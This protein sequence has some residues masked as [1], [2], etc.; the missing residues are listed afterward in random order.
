[1]FQQSAWK[2]IGRVLVGSKQSRQKILTAPAL[3]DEATESCE[4]A[5]DG[6]LLAPVPLDRLALRALLDAAP[7][8][9]VR[10]SAPCVGAFD[11]KALTSQPG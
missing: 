4:P 10:P 2:F 7:V 11:E 6:S 8:G 5:G 3:L 9:V 1:M